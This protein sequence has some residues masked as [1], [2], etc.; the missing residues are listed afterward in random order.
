[1]ATDVLIT[2]GGVDIRSRVRDGSLTIHDAL[3]DAPNTASLTIEGTA[4]AAGQTL[5]VSVDSAAPVLLFNGTLQ[6]V[7]LGYE[8]FP[9][10]LVYRCTAI[11]DLARLNRRL[12]FGTWTNASATTIAQSLIADFA[13]GFSDTGVEAGLPLVSVNFDGSEGFSGC[14]RQLAKLIGGYFYVED[15]DL[16]LFQT[17]ATDLPDDLDGTPGRLEDDPPITRHE[18]L[19]QLRTRVYGKGH[20]EAT[21]AEVLAGAAV[22]PVA[23]ATAW[24][25]P[26]GG[27]AIS[28]TQ[29]L[30]YTG[31]GLGYAPSIANWLVRNGPV[32]VRDWDGIA[33]SPALQLFVAVAGSGTTTDVMTSPDGITWTARTP[34]VTSSW[35]AVTW[36]PALTLFCAVSSAGL[37]M[38]SPDGVTWTQRTAASASGWTAIVW[39]P[40]LSLF[41][42]V[43]TSGASQVMTSPDGITWTSRTAAAARTWQGVAWSPALGLFAACAASGGVDCIMTSP[44]GTTWT[45][46]TAPSSAYNAIAWSPAAGRFVAVG[47]TG[48]TA[49]ALSSADGITWTARAAANGNSWQAVIW[50]DDLGLFVAVAKDGAGTTTNRIMASPD[51]IAWTGY[52]TPSVGA[53]FS[54]AWGADQLVAVGI[55]SGAVAQ[56]MTVAPPTFDTLTGVTGLVEPLVAGAPIHVWVQRDDLAAQAAMAAIDGGD[57]I[58]EHRLSDE[59]RGEASL[60]DLCDAELALFSM[61]I[62]TVTYATRDTKTKSG[63]PIVINLTS[64]PI[65]ETLTIQDVTIDQIDQYVNTNPRFTVTASSVRFSLEDLLRRMAADLEAA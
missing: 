20:G 32:T 56:I 52:L 53:W 30:T 54:V 27:Q 6:T 36:A 28:D 34:A 62:V 61:P 29:V 41:V 40:D 13:P 65:S 45:Q 11:D 18:D 57:G 19:S 63:K 2:L 7:A 51:G 48:G 47:G 35:R 23:N 5:R 60:I 64:P 46:R 17:E 15:L 50:V 8:G 9:I 3:N 31:L 43:A 44:T 1:M 26:A 25:Q 49:T 55:I 12:P 37:V 59:R 38:T 21:L 22:I 10:Q 14:L 39:S 4:P 42:A 24:F 16:H 33:W 58:Y